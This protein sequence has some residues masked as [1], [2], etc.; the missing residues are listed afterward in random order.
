MINY[1]YKKISSATLLWSILYSLV[2]CDISDFEDMNKSPNASTKIVPSYVLSSV[3]LEIRDILGDTRTNLYMQYMSQ[4]QYTNTSLYNSSKF[5]YY[6]LYIDALFP[7]KKIK[8]ANTDESTKSEAAKYGLNANQIAVTEILSC[9]FFH[10]MT[11]RWGPVPYLESLQGTKNLKPRIDTQQTVYEDIFK[12]LDAA[13]AMIKSGEIQGD[14]IFRGDMAKWKRFANV[15]RATMALRLSDIAPAMAKAEFVKANKAGLLTSNA[16]NIAFPYRKESAWENPWYTRFRSRTD[17]ALSKPFVD[18]LKETKDKR[19][20]SFGEKASNVK[21]KSG[22]DAYAGL[23]YGLSVANVGK[24]DKLSY[25]F[26][27][28]THVR[29]QDQPLYVYTYAQVLFMQAE[30]R[31][32]GWI[33]D[34]D[35]KT[36]YEKAIKASIDQWKAFT[37]SS[38]KAIESDIQAF[39]DGPKVKWDS[40]KAIQLIGEQKWV[41]LF[42]QGYESWAEWRRLDFP[43]L[44]PAP[45]A[46]NESKTIPVRDPYHDDVST[47]NEANYKYAVSTYLGGKD[48]LNTKVWWDKK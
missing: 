16:D 29:V 21:N 32:K 13:I 28:K 34:S 37:D 23:K 19:L 39:L 6:D 2:A 24:I 7:L 11:D 10:H 43:K 30:A 36:L 44:K 8:E 38:G 12:R 3:L 15:L 35:P 17:Y 45:D 48:K 4:T 46:K 41:A 26:P 18:F 25:C 27:S 31:H 20:F 42:L 9:Y 1:L 5:G 33:T 14:F 47:Y 40:S 22:F